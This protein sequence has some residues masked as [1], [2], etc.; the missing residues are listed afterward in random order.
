M[1]IENKYLHLDASYQG[2]STEEL[3]DFAEQRLPENFDALRN[4]LLRGEFMNASEGRKVSHCLSRSGHS[5]VAAGN[6]KNRFS[7]IVREL[8]SGRWLGATGKPIE[9]VVNIGVGGS[10]LG[11]MM[12]SFALREFADDSSLHNL[13]VHFVSSMDG[14]NYMPYCRW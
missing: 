12:G 5:V 8:R 11:P 4:Q 6:G 9:H 13:Q 10:D 3:K 7:D 14:G 2:L 1:L